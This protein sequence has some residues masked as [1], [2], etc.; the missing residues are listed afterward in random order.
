MS[1]GLIIFGLF[2][3]TWLLMFLVAHDLRNEIRNGKP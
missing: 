3:M 1:E 2:P